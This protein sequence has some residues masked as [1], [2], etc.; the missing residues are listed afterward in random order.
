MPNLD[1][2]IVEFS[3]KWAS[4]CEL[5]GFEIVC[6]HKAMLRKEFNTQLSF[7]GTAKQKITERKSFFRRLVESKGSPRIDWEDVICMRKRG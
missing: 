1:K 2:Q 4:L 6:W 5:V 3:Q 7:D